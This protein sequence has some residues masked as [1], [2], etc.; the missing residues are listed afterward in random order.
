[1]FLLQGFPKILDAKVKYFTAL[2][3]AVT[4]LKPVG[5]LALAAYNAGEGAVAKYGGIPPYAETQDYVVKVMERMV[6]RQEEF[7]RLREGS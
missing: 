1:M 7:L 4:R 5:I 2:S 3:K 6:K